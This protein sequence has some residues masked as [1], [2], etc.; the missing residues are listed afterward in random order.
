MR[1]STSRIAQAVA[2]YFAFLTRGESARL[3]SIDA[4][5][6]PAADGT[7]LLLGHELWIE[8]LVA[9]RDELVRSAERP[10]PLWQFSWGPSARWDAESWRALPLCAR[11]V[12]ARAGSLSH[13]VE[14]RLTASALDLPSAQFFCGLI[15]LQKAG[16]ASDGLPFT[17]EAIAGTDEIRVDLHLVE[18]LVHWLRM[19]AHADRIIRESL[20]TAFDICGYAGACWRCRVRW[21]IQPRAAE[22]VPPFHPGCRC[23]AQPRFTS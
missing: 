11:I 19:L 6:F 1:N 14:R 8:P 15:A 17:L 20:G 23:F 22:V 7:A 12:R 16:M 21:G 4:S 13:R 3:S 9:F 5:A 10:P 18:L 2:Q